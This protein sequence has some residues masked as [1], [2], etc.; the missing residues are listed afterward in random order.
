MVALE[1][2]GLVYTIEN[3]TATGYNILWLNPE[4]YET[5]KSGPSQVETDAKWKLF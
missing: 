1:M 3:S 2:Q 4:L 5:I